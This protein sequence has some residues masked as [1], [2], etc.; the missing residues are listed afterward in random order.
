M[1]VDVILDILL[2]RLIAVGS[3]NLLKDIE[4]VFSGLNCVTNRC[5]GVTLA[6]N[7][8]ENEKTWKI[9]IIVDSKLC[10]LRSLVRQNLR[11]AA[12]FTRG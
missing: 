5:P 1:H 12:P 3:L 7:P 10:S 4:K 9:K 8:H 6:L 2:A 11:R